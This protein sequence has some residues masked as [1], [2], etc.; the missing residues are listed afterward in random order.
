[1]R[2]IGIL[3]LGACTTSGGEPKPDLNGPYSCGRLTCGTGEICTTYSAGSQCGVDPSRGIGP[4]DLISASCEPLPA[5]CNGVPSCGCVT[6][7]G[8][9]FGEHDREVSFGCI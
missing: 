2:W 9:C 4:Y 1:M 8:I 3:L 5:K 6:N 7:I